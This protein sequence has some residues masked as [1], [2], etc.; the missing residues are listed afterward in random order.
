MV[1]LFEFLMRSVLNLILNMS[2]SGGPTEDF[3]KSDLKLESDTSWSEFLTL[4]AGE[5]F[6]LLFLES[7]LYQNFRIPEI[8]FETNFLGNENLFQKTGVSFFSW[9]LR[10]KTHHFHSKLLCQKLML[11]QIEWRLH[12]GPIT[13]S[14][15][16]PVTT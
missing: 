12:N 15:V 8:N 6:F 14:W 2:S 7:R 10:L 1:T 4:G 16:L 3:A 11:R 13:K 5:Y 9:K